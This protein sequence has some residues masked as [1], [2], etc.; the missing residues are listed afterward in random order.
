LFT[1][2]QPAV[3][4]TDR[5]H[6]LV[7]AGTADFRDPVV[8]FDA[9][10]ASRIVVPADK[11]AGL[12][13]G[14]TWF[15][16]LIAKNP[17]GETESVSPAKRFVVDPA[18]PPLADSELSEFGERAD[19]VMVEAPLAGSPEPAFG[20]LKS[21]QGWKPVP[22]PKGQAV[23]AVELDGQTGMLTYAVKTFPA[24]RY[25][26]SLWFSCANREPRLGQ[27][28]SAWCRGMDDPLR[29]CVENGEL[30]ARIEA[31]QFY[32]TQ[33]APVE[34]GKWYHVGVVKDGA[35]LTLFLD[36]REAAGT[37][38]PAKIRSQAR[39][40]ALG[41]NPHYT[42]ASEHLQCRVA[43]LSMSA[44][45]LTSEEVGAIYEDSSGTPR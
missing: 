13:P 43:G 33:P 32:R 41:G 12:K 23:G 5:T 18:L 36:G 6:E 1:L 28:F 7:L 37:D 40:F 19:G 34:P 16:K 21:A 45:A 35:R 30:S 29:I 3:E 31:G 27:V 11:T 4:A 10:S 2:H 42:G 17:F 22:R 44:R 20:E 8:R 9:G 14:G 24:E 25:T 15:W 26:V 38:V 39:D